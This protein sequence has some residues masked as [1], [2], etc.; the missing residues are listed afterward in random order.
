MSKIL[1]KTA[2]III[3]VLTIVLIGLNITL[4][5]VNDR[6]INTGIVQFK[7]HR[8]EISIID[9]DSIILQPEELTINSNTTRKITIKNPATSMACVLRIWLEFYVNGE[10]DTNYLSFNL[11]EENFV[12]SDSGKYY[13]KNVLASN[14]S[15]EN[16][17]LN[18]SVSNIDAASYQGKKYGLKLFVESI[19]STK[20]A[21]DEWS[22]DYPTTWRTDI[23]SSLTL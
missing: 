18:F 3:S 19:Q 4:A 10:I 14:Q 6:K 22:T 8:L 13:Y 21:V 11:G 1:N 2:I 20:A 15:L 16:L 9:D 12:V 5:L 17:V 7:E 23:D